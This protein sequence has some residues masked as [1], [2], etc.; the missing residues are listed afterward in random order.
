MT[1]INYKP[2]P[3]DR[4]STGDRPA[5]YATI[6]AEGAAQLPPEVT[7]GKNGL[8]P[9]HGKTLLNLLWNLLHTRKGADMLHNN[10]PSSGGNNVQQRA[11]LKAYF[12]DFGV[13]NPSL[14][15]A[16]I[17]AHFAATQWV[18]HTKALPSVNVV[19]REQQEQIYLQKMSHVMW[20]LWEDAKGDDFS[21]AW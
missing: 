14:Q 8:D 19:A 1:E 13:T 6:V 20:M 2:R 16:L 11:N 3:N 9:T 10:K 15:D 5:G 7:Q 4:N 17:D 21:M 18:E 12:A